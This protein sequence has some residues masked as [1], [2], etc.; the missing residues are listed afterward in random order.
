MES[1]ADGPPIEAFLEMPHVQLSFEDRDMSTDEE[2]S[3]IKMLKLKYRGRQEWPMFRSYG[4][5]QEAL[6]LTVGLERLKKLPVR[7][8]RFE[9]DVFLLPN[10]VRENKGE[11]PYYPYLLMILNP[12]NGAS[13]SRKNRRYFH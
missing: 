7:R 5:A 9:M 3:L 10:A 12:K 8:G 13:T 6:F 11:R 4:D 2:R 1:E